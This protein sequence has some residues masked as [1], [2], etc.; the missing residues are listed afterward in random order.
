MNA[1]QALRRLVYSA[2]Q[3]QNQTKELQETI[4]WAKELLAKGEQV[5]YQELVQALESL[6][7]ALEKARAAE[8]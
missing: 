7:G 1:Y 5:E 6:E 3:R 8:N 4:Q 2:G